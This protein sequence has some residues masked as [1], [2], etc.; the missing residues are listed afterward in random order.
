MRRQFKRRELCA[1]CQCDPGRVAIDA[2]LIVIKRL[3]SDFLNRRIRF[4]AE[5]VVCG[6]NEHGVSDD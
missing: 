4:E 1:F 6:V 5:V 2:G 3:E